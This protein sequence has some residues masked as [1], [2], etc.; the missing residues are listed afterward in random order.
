MKTQLSLWFVLLIAGAYVV[1][2]EACHI[3]AGGGSFSAPFGGTMS[4]GQ[5]AGLWGV[6]SA[7]AMTLL[8]LLAPQ[9]LPVL[10]KFLPGIKGVEVVGQIDER[11]K[12][13]NERTKRMDAKLD[14][15]LPPQ[16]PS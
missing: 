10:E 5:A 15:L 2:A 12:E 7:A 8:G 3:Y 13:I 16:Q 9:V 4:E 1:G 11:T 14:R 6:L